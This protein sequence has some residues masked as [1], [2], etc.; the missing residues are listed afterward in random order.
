MVVVECS[1]NENIAIW[2]VGT[3]N[4][5]G[6][7]YVFLRGVSKSDLFM[8]FMIFMIFYVFYSFLFF[9]VFYFL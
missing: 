1:V 4:E 6:S 3:Q 5:G 2:L 7:K 9:I 8:T